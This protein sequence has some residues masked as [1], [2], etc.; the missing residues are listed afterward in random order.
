MTA[1]FKFAREMVD[2][3]REL[4]FEGI[5]VQQHRGHP[6]LSAIIRGRPVSYVFAGSPS[7]VRAQKNCFADL[8]RLAKQ[9]VT[10]K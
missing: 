10:A 9:E 8:K 3:A 1:S 4:G 7:D 2:K 5:K 6:K